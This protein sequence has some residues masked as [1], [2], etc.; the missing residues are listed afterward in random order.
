MHF[1]EK[2]NILQIERENNTQATILSKLTQDASKFE[3]SVYIEEITKPSINEEVILL[4]TSSESW[5]TS[6]I[7]YL[8]NVCLP[9]ELTKAQQLKGQS[10]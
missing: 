1:L 10:R 5:M 4:L 7:K 3:T 2:V 8:G 9:E 6:L